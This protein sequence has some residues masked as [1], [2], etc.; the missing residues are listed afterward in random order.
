MIFH[1]VTLYWHCT[2][3]WLCFLYAERRASTIFK[4]WYNCMT[5][6]AIPV[7][8]RTLYQLSHCVCLWLF[9][10]GVYS[11]RKEFAPKGSKFL[12]FG[13][14]P[15][16]ERECVRKKQTGSNKSCQQVLL[17]SF[18]FLFFPW[19]TRKTISDLLSICE[20]HIPR[21]SRSYIYSLIRIVAIRIYLFQC[22]LWFC[23]WAAKALSRSQTRRL[24]L[25]FAVYISPENIFSRLF[26]WRVQ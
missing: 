21:T 22:T 3:S 1:S 13:V 9:W 15:F 10:K 25:A 14:E 11:K 6:P 24:P 17:L 20:Q 16:P 7:T 4:V 12:P 2:D 23:L 5:R 18:L 8:K 26:N 19:G